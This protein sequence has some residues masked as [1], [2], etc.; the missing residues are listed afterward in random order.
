MGFGFVF[1]GP[2]AGDS[3]I[4]QS[5]QLIKFCGQGS[6]P[7]NE[8]SFTGKTAFQLVFWASRRGTM[9]AIHA[10]FFVGVYGSLRF[11]FLQV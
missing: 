9:G 5:L 7:L 8:V 10:M 1:F 4:L 2:R 11:R 6:K 3:G